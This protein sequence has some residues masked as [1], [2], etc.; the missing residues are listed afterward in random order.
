MISNYYLILKESLIIQF[1]TSFFLKRLYVEY[2]HMAGCSRAASCVTKPSF[3]FLGP[4]RHVLILP[5]SSSWPSLLPFVTFCFKIK[6]Q[7][8]LLGKFWN[9]GKILAKQSLPGIIELKVELLKCKMR[10]NIPRGRVTGKEKLAPTRWPDAEVQRRRGRSSKGRF[11]VGLR[12]CE[13]ELASWRR[14]ST[15][16]PAYCRIQTTNDEMRMEHL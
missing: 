14:S 7:F 13:T 15:V 5:L 12:G 4:S 11:K 6:S 16:Y 10:T 9:W 3:T 8:R 2:L 1:S